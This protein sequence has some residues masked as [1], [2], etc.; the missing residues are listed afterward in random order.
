MLQVLHVATIK[1]HI[2]VVQALLDFGFSTTM[3]NSRGWLA[4]D[5]AVM[6][7]NRPLVRLSSKQHTAL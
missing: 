4:L 6:L 5:E 7:K 1:Q 2:R 3:Q